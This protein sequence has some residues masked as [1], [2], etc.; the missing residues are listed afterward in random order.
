MMLWQ[1]LESSAR[2]I[3]LTEPHGNRC[4]DPRKPTVC[5]HRTNVVVTWH[6]AGHFERAPMLLASEPMT[7]GILHPP[8]LATPEEEALVGVPAQPKPPATLPAN[9]S[10]VE[11][12]VSLA[13]YMAQT[14][15][16][17]YAFSVAANAILSLFPF[18]VMM[19]TIARLVFHSARDGERDRGHDPLFPAHRPAI[20]HQEHGDCGPRAQ[21]G[22]GCLGGHVA[23]FFDRRFSAAGSGPEPGLGRHQK[24]LLPH[25]P[26]GLPRPGCRHWHAG[27]GQRRRHRGAAIG[28]ADAVLWPHR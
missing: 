22:A 28:F 4:R 6:R 12:I 24:P 10:L 7:L 2:K 25:E 19:F 21:R 13:R 16:H 17:T 8:D 20:R 1:E 18:I 26:A 9:A 3:C 5:C 14:E 27:P 15:V 11:E 23:G